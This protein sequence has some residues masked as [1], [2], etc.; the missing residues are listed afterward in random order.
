MTFASG[1]SPSLQHARFSTLGES[2]GW[3]AGIVVTISPFL[4]WYAGTLDGLRVAVV[5]WDTGALGKLTLLIGL[6]TLAVL[7]VRAAG[8]ELPP[9]VPLGMVVA[10]LGAVGTVFVLIRIAT[11]P[12]DY[13]ELG[14]AVGLWISLIAAVLLVVAGLLQSAEDA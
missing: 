2:L 3:I 7:V 5:G 12:D 9:N 11:V 4:G 8:V 13:V 1:R 6:A 14:R 10:F